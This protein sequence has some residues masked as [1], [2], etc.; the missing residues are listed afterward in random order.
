[1]KFHHLIFQILILALLC[2]AER[3]K[4]NNCRAAK[5]KFGDDANAWPIYLDK[6]CD[7]QPD[8][9][10]V[11]I[12][13]EHTEIYEGI[14]EAYG[15]S[16]GSTRYEMVLANG[17]TFKLLRG[18]QHEACYWFIV[19]GSVALYAAKCFHGRESN[20]PEKGWVD[21]ALGSGKSK[22]AVAPSV[23]VRVT[24]FEIESRPLLT[25]RLD[26]TVVATAQ[27]QQSQ[28]ARREEVQRQVLSSSGFF[29]VPDA[30]DDQE[31]VLLRSMMHPAVSR[32]LGLALRSR[33]TSTDD[34]P[35]DAIS[36]DG[37]FNSTLLERALG[38]MRVSPTLWHPPALPLMMHN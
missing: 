10:R 9:Y 16:G 22:A 8:A 5:I 34:R 26:H 7:E 17:T 3:I 2:I 12:D 35:V 1:M 21:V 25:R 19:R 4:I 29:S 31:A 14:Y 30:K 13:K 32:S 27:E 37:L 15:R 28:E 24:P 33:Y 20:P 18:R 38:F 11:V 6:H 23:K 36:I